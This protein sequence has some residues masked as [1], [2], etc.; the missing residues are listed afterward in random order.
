MRLLLVSGRFLLDTGTS[1]KTGRQMGQTRGS[2]MLHTP[3][4]QDAKG[5]QAQT[6]LH[7]LPLLDGECILH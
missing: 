7:P 4:L 6:H 2:R 5:N 1:S 3:A